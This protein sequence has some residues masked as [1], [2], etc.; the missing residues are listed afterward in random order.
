MVR[1]LDPWRDRRH[2]CERRSAT[3]APPVKHPPGSRMNASGRI[4]VQ[5]DE[6]R[7]RCDRMALLGAHRLRAIDQPARPDALAASRL[8]IEQT[9]PL[10]A[11]ATPRANEH[12]PEAAVWK[13]PYSDADLVL[14]STVSEPD[15][16][17]LCVP[18]DLA[19]RHQ[20]RHSN[21]RQIIDRA[22]HKA[23]N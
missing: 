18:P 1:V 13:R 21:Q 17:R 20:S 6:T 16:R 12:R 4:A 19:E 5:H 9:K 8:A 23:E 11:A 15:A 7:R 2:V 22:L 10:R 14:D 3:A